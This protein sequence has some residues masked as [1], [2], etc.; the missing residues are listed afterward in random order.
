MQR[1]I[2]DT[3]P[4]I[5]DALALFLAL[6]SPE[7]QLE[8]ITT[9]SGNVGVELT[10]L[11]ALSLLT[12]TGH[13]EIPVARGSGVPLVRERVDAADVHGRNGLGDVT[14]PTPQIQPLAQHAVDLIIEKVLQA[15]GAL[16]LVAIGPLTNLA[17]AVRREP[18][19][20]ELVREVVVM[21]G[22]LFVPGN[23][24]PA[25]EFNI[26]A[27][28]H[29]ASIVLHAGWPLRLVSLDTTMLAELSREQIASMTQAHNPVLTFCKEI[30]AYY[31]DIFAA[32]RGQRVFH[33]HDPLCL[34][35]AFQP[36][37]IT[38]QPMYVDIELTG[39]LTLGET[40]GYLANDTPHAP[41]AQVSVG[42]DSERF[43]RM[44]LERMSKTYA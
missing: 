15:P 13:T 42:V 11:N 32:P 25:A 9:V 43:A 34:A 18:R 35:A 22:A 33:M 10:T 4:G 41:N 1:I 3:D 5:D 6:A 12:L 31:L 21:G 23:I 19:I 2:L 29:A 38:W 17:L 14:L 44:F 27:D 20:A 37:L 36:D 8:A 26:Y 16:T 28:P 24:T 7:V 30:L 39:T 40:L